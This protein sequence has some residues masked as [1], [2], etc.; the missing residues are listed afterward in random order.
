[1][2]S[3]LH[4]FIKSVLMQLYLYE[5][6]EESEI[7]EVPRQI[8]PYAMIEYCYIPASDD[9]RLRSSLRCLSAVLLDLWCMWTQK[10]VINRLQYKS[11][12]KVW[13]L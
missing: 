1:M 11:S 3:W 4:K 6:T 13:S 10:T 5:Y 8:C 7:A 12:L 2:L 9:G